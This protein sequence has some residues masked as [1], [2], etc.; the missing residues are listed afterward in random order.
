MATYRYTA[1]L[2]NRPKP[3]M[4]KLTVVTGESLSSRGKKALAAGGAIGSSANITRGW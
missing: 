4:A 2:Q 3:T 1:T